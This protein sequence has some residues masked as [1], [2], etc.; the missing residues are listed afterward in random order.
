MIFNLYT[1]ECF[2]LT[3]ILGLSHVR[4][5]DCQLSGITW[6][7]THCGGFAGHCIRNLAV[8]FD[9]GYFPKSVDDPH[10]VSD[11]LCAHDSEVHLLALGN[12]L[13]Q[14][15]IHYASLSEC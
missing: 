6:E 15:D 10:C 12:F 13:T 3:I 7:F 11:V 14:T 9:K 1:H 2:L 5:N 8:C 4:S